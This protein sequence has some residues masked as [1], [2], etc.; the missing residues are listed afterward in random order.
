MRE[1]MLHVLMDGD[2]MGRLM[3]QKNGK[4]SFGYDSGWKGH[5]LSVSMPLTRTEHKSELVEAFLWGLLP[6]NPQAIDA[7]AKSTERGGVC[8]PQDIFS[9]IAKVGMDCAGAAQFVREQDLQE[10]TSGGEARPI[11]EAEIAKTLHR[12]RNSPAPQRQVNRNGQFSLAGAQPKTA[13][14]K[15]DKGWF[16]PSGRIATTHI[17]KPLSPMLD[18]LIVNEHLCLRVAAALGQIASQTEIVRFKKQPALVV[19]RYDRVA[20][21]FPPMRLHQE[22]MCQANGVPPSR[23]YENEQGPGIRTIID[24]LRRHSTRPDEDV[25]RFWEAIILN[26]LLQGTD[27]HAKNYSMLL[28]GQDIRLAPLYDIISYHPYPDSAHA[29]MPMKIGGK[30]Y[31]AELMPRHWDRMAKECGS[32]PAFVL[33]MVRKMAADLPDAIS[34]E[35]AALKREKFMP[36]AYAEIQSKTVAACDRVKRFYGEGQVFGAALL[37]SVGQDLQRQDE[38]RRKQAQQAER[39]AERRKQLSGHAGEYLTSVAFRLFEQIEQLA[40]LV[41]IDSQPN[42][43][44]ARLSTARLTMTLNHF[45]DIPQG[46]FQHSGWDVIRGDMIV[47]EAARTRMGASLWFTD[48]GTGEYHWY[49]VAYWNLAETPPHLPTALAPGRDADLAI[50]AGESHPW[51]LAHPP[52]LLDDAHLDDFFDRWMGRFAHAARGTLKPPPALPEKS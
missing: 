26:W 48:L 46:I 25:E 2:A 43:L 44:E 10:A 29:A 38:E 40:P 21:T 30:R 24:T 27:A 33:T 42:G 7:I 50:L 15:T 14:L 3:R 18:G 4:L 9:L 37:A 17:M 35:I 6:E 47:V 39:Q 20:G 36:T 22:D 12:L 49:E 51:R 41:E 32:D 16:E 13:Y 23:K 5:P 11:T 8:S 19:T 52:R 28:S 1:T 45:A 31:F 34:D